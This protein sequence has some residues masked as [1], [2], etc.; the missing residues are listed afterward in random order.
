MKDEVGHYADEPF[1]DHVL[2][3]RR[4]ARQRPAVAPFHEPPWLAHQH[5]RIVRYLGNREVLVALHQRVP[6]A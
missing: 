5:A 6:V 3:E 1:A 2:A 4:G